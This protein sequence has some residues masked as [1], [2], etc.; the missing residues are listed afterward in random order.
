MGI[1]GSTFARFLLLKARHFS[2]LLAVSALLGYFKALSAS[3]FMLTM[4]EYCGRRCPGK[5]SSAVSM[6][7][8]SSG[9]AMVSLGQLFGWLRGVFGS[10]SIT[11]CAENAVVYLIC[12]VWLFK[13]D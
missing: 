9:L 12:V 13:L 2:W 10:Y 6:S 7:L 1:I 8:M 4:A 3:N 5:V 11:F